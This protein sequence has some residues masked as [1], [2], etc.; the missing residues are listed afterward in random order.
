M[1][2]FSPDSIARAKKT[3]VLVDVQPDWLHFDGAR[4]GKVMSKEAMRYFIPLS[5]LVDAGVLFA[6]ERYMVGWGRTQQL[7][8]IIRSWECGL[9][10]RA[11]QPKA[12]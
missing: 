2:V 7:T 4:L 9:R 10:L 8:P 5:S 11:R 1:R 6:A 3:G 12:R